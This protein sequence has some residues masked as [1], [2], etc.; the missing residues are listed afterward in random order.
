MFRWTKRNQE[1]RVMGSWRNNVRDLRWGSKHKFCSPKSVTIPLGWQCSSSN[2]FLCLRPSSSRKRRKKRRKKK[3][4]KDRMRKPLDYNS[5][6]IKIF[7]EVKSMLMTNI[8]HL[9]FISNTVQV[10]YFLNCKRGWREESQFPPQAC[11]YFFITNRG[12]GEGE[13]ANPQIL[14]TWKAPTSTPDSFSFASTTGEAKKNA[15]HR[16]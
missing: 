13:I 6:F 11:N 3:G 5:A 2:S 1:P 4:E 8:N 15:W 16:V 7:T 10:L 12:R 9:E 14:L